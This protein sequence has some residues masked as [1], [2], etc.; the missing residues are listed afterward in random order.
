MSSA[1][2]DTTKRKRATAAGT[3]IMV[4]LQPDQLATLDAWI[5]SQPQQVSRPEAIRAILAAGL[6]VPGTPERK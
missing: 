4:R 3:P 6:V 5:A 2:R 1:S